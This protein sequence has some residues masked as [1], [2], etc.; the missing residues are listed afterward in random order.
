MLQC[1]KEY[2]QWERESAGYD[3]E[4]GLMA[5][6]RVELAV[7]GSPISTSAA[8]EAPAMSNLLEG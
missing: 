4:I 2:E 1:I 3:V 7:K 5:C 6:D 8:G